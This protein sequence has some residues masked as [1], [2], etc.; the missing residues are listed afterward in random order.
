VLLTL[1]Y[2]AVG[3]VQYMFF[4]WIEYYFN[5]VLHLSPAASREAA[6]VATM[7]MAVGMACGGW[8]SDRLCR[9]LGHVRGCRVMAILGMGLSAGF[10]LAGASTTDAQ[11]VQWYFSLSL[12]SLGLCEGIFWTTAPTLEPRGG[13]LAAAFLNTGGNALGLLAPVVTPW[14]GEHYG[15]RTAVT[16]ACVLCGVGGLLWFGIRSGAADEGGP[17]T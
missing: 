16:V 10:A 12:G 5:K 8:V 1:S 17:A 14:L 15:W 7:A 11:E 6:F 13:G 9:A 2:G 4:Y 3:Y